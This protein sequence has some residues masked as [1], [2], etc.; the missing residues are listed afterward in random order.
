MPVA[1]LLVRRGYFARLSGQVRLPSGELSCGPGRAALPSTPPVDGLSYERPAVLSPPGH[2]PVCCG[3][4]TVT[5]PPSV[6]AKTAQKHDYPRPHGGRRTRAVLASSAAFRTIKDPASNDISRGGCALMGLSAVTVLRLL[7][8]R[9]QL[10]GGSRVSGEDD[11]LFE[12]P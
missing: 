1:H 4:K 10:A 3:Q 7:P 2:V 8:G 5:V 11:V 6:N 9:A 12:L